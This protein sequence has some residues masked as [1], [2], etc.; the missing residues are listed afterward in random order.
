VSGALVAANPA[1][2]I[3]SAGQPGPG[4]QPGLAGLQNRTRPMALAHQQR[5]AVSSSLS[6]VLPDGVQRGSTV[7]VGSARTLG[8]TSLALGLLAGV[9]ASGG[10]CAVVGL[11][12]LGLVAAAQLGLCLERLALIPDPGT[13][14]PVVAAALLD[15]VDMVLLAPPQ[16][17]TPRD[18]RRLAARA[19]ERGA[20]MVIP[21]TAWPNRGDL[22]LT[23][24]SVAWSG[25]GVGQGYLQARRAEVVVAGRGSATRE[26]RAWTWLPDQPTR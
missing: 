21:A 23:V 3:E 17:A 8:T 11:P 19:R 10:W 14:W 1:A 13:Q 4:G 16:R 25:L 20:V 7:V 24:G 6:A 2:Q 18:A 22:H 26:R 12:S 9:S 15:S 5:L